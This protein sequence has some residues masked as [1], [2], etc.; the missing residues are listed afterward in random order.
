MLYFAYRRRDLPF[1]L[2]YLMFT[3]FIFSCGTTHFLAAY[4]IYRPEYWIEGYV[5]A[6]TAAVSTLTVIMFIPRIPEVIAL[7]SIISTHDEIKK[8]NLELNSKNIEL[9]IANFSIENVL[10]PIYWISSDAKILRANNAA[11]ISLGYTT[12][13]LLTFTVADLDLNFSQEQ[14]TEQWSELKTKKSLIL[15]TQH[16]KKDG[17]FLD[18]EISVNYITYEGQEFH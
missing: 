3:L 7:P 10:V 2:I 18:V 11:C 6:F 14:W 16:R 5:K 13:E 4:T 1:Y 12:E 9:E 17:S 8:L 15:E